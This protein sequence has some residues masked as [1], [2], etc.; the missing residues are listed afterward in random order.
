MLH[1][2]ISHTQQAN[3]SQ[4]QTALDHLISLLT[5]H[6]QVQTK[7]TSDQTGTDVSNI[8]NAQQTQLDLL[9][10]LKGSR[11]SETADDKVGNVQYKPLW[12]VPL[13]RNSNFVGREDVLEQ[14]R[15]SLSKRDGIMPVAVLH[16]LGGV[17]CVIIR[18]R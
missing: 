14:V 6:L 5:L 2:E 3:V 13:S 1:S 18:L 9:F 17:G 15:E 8:L 12:M 16:G 11:D 4:L 10:H 7:R